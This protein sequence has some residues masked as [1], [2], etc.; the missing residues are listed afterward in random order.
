MTISSTRR[1][2]AVVSV[3][4]PL[5][6]SERPDPYSRDPREDWEQVP[7]TDGQH[8]PGCRIELARQPKS[9]KSRI[10][11]MMRRITDTPG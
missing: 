11:R 2:A 7:P 10:G 4:V 1:R 5:R 3:G 8:C 9:R 6:V